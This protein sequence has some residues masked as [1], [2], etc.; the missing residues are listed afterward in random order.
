MENQVHPE[1]TTFLSAMQELNLT[2]ENIAESRS[3][4]N[5][6]LGSEEVKMEN[7][8]TTERFIT[9]PNGA[10]DVRIRIYEPT[11]KYGT[12]PAILYIHGGGFIIGSIEMFDA[13]CQMLVSQLDCV[14]VSVGYRLAPEHPYPA[15]VEDCYTALEWVAANADELGIDVTRLAVHGASAG[16]GLTAAVSLLARDRKGPKIA[17][18]MPLYPMI[19]N[20]CI[21]PS[22]DEITDARVWNGPQ[23]H[24]AWE[25][26][27][28]PN[29]AVDAPIYAAPLHA[30]D[31]SN[32]PPTYTFIGDLDPFRDETIEYIA[33]L[34]KAGVPTEFHLYP[35]CFHGFEHMVPQ[36]EISQ[37]AIENYMHAF[38]KAFE[39]AASPTT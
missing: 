26:Y 33:R 30:E 34:T 31:Y 4:M 17:F 18:Q 12:L 1:L 20:R 7:V 8:T 19:D 35:G 37:R 36:A 38:K 6:A 2:R 21:L 9:S 5:E 32:L 14:V 11:E 23:N 13:S 10:P 28:G 29:Y 22:N 39:K 27:L 24:L 25:M 16:G 3:V 15:G